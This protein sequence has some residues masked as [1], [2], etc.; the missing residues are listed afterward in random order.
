M[1][2]ITSWCSSPVL[3]WAPPPS[4]KKSSH[5]A[6]LLYF[7]G[8]SLPWQWKILHFHL[9][10]H[11]GVILKETMTITEPYVPS[12]CTTFHS[13]SQAAFLSS[14]VFAVLLHQCSFVIA[15]HSQSS[16]HANQGPSSTWGSEY[17]HF[18]WGVMKTGFQE[19]FRAASNLWI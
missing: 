8:K 4:W 18:L 11:S 5:R 2:C 14:D 3:I 1:T 13:S 17:R 9:L 15:A 19:S 12:V 7:Y 16:L 6:L 10:T